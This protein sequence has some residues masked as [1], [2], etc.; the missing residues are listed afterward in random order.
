MEPTTESP[1][2]L[3][4]RAP[5]ILL[6]I[7]ALAW[8]LGA[9][10]CLG[11]VIEAIGMHTLQEVLLRTLIY[12]PPAL[13]PA[14]VGFGLWR[15]RHWAR[16]SAL[17][18]G[19]LAL[20][21]LIIGGLVSFITKNGFLLVILMVV[22]LPTTVFVLLQAYCLTRPAMKA[23]FGLTLSRDPLIRKPG[24]AILPFMK[25]RYWLILVLAVA[26]TSLAAWFGLRE[27]H[28]IRYQDAGLWAELSAKRVPAGLM[29]DRRWFRVTA[30][31]LSI[32][33]SPTDPPEIALPLPSELLSSWAWRV[34]VSE[35]ENRLICVNER[36]LAV[37]RAS[38]P[39]E[40]MRN[41]SI[42][43]EPM[44]GPKIGTANHGS[45]EYDRHKLVLAYS[46]SP[47]GRLACV[48]AVGQTSYSHE[49]PRD[50]IV[51]IRDLETGHDVARLVHPDAG[52][53]VELVAW[54]GDSKRLATHTE[55]NTI[56]FWE[57]GN[58][59]QLNRV[60]LDVDWFALSRDGTV[61]FTSTRLQEV[62]QRL[63]FRLT[64]LRIADGS[65][66]QSRDLQYLQS[67]FLSPN[68]M[69]I[70]AV[71]YPGISLLDSSTLETLWFSSLPGQVAS[72][73]FRED[74]LE[75]VAVWGI[76]NEIYGSRAGIKAWETATG[77]IVL[78]QKGLGYSES[79]RLL[80]FCGDGRIVAG[81]HLFEPVPN[82]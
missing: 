31:T 67:V 78:K 33:Q 40:L 5:A 42:S 37:W 44:A 79:T 10:A 74:S 64:V 71:T 73:A 32:G 68:E 27:R 60:M 30:S 48:H 38:P 72:V 28:N 65:V 69:Y 22:G 54:S 6:K 56:T 82:P 3:R 46:E 36:G 25:L 50:G 20:S 21:L 80:G 51:V 53:K 61:M 2:P 39:Y 12:L 55:D 14:A 8:F 57:I 41:W 76:P 49:D 17:L 58:Q 47:D 7:L 75:L 70:A 1:M 34:K 19:W 24:A 29:S 9:I 16:K 45:T 4:S 18:I 66:I 23:L 35:D 52:L 63:R 62:K 59:S 81:R 13:V 26:T 43:T 77:T 15:K 11:E